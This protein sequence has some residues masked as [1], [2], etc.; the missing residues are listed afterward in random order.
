MKGECRL[1][2]PHHASVDNF[3]ADRALFLMNACLEWEQVRCSRCGSRFKC[4]SVFISA[5]RLAEVC[6]GTG[7][8]V[9]GL[10]MGAAWVLT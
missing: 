5:H 6:V 8:I 4:E 10:V 1:Q 7:T 3:M 9:I 2:R